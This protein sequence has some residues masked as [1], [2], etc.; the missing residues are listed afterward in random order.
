MGPQLAIVS[1]EVLSFEP[2]PV[3]KK[4]SSDR[5]SKNPKALETYVSP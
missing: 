1:E 3:S 4:I 2:C 5:T